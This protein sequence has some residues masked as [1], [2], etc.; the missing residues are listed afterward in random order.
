MLINVVL[1]IHSKGGARGLIVIFKEKVL[2][3]HSILLLEGHHYLV[4]ETE[5][6]QLQQKRE[7]RMLSDEEERQES[8]TG[9]HPG[10]CV[11]ALSA[12]LHLL[13]H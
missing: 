9:Q 2:E 13:H 10:V 8:E 6:H 1:G 12:F 4:A 3:S 11:Q 7:L 5:H